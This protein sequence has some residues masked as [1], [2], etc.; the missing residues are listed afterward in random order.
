MRETA[1][2][3]SGRATARRYHYVPSSD[4]SAPLKFLV[5]LSLLIVLLAVLAGVAL[6]DWAGSPIREGART[7]IEVTIVPRSSVRSIA[8]QLADAGLPIQPLLL[9]ALARFEGRATK[10]QAGTYV[11]A[12]SSTPDAVLTK[13][14]SGDVLRIAL[15]IPEGWTFAQMRAAIARHPDIKQTAAAMT[16]A[17]LMAAIGAA[18]SQPE[19]E[20]FPDTYIFTRGTT[21]LD[22]FRR[23]YRA[24]QKR[25]ADAW[26]ARAADL[27]FATPYEALT[28]ASVVE[29][30]TG[31]AEDR[32][33]IAA[34]FVNRL[35]RGM[36]LQ[37]DPTV[38][39]GM[40]ARFDGN[41]RKA[42]LTSDTPYNTYLRPGLPPTPIALVGAAALAAVVNPPG[43]DA[44]YFVSRGDGT[45]VFSNRLVDHNRAVD[46][47]QRGRFDGAP[48]HREKP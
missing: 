6:H 36:L 44:L 8:T 10:L 47:Y 1:S 3:A 2:A 34:V 27:P 12:S 17:E 14:E 41:L 7:G 46:R 21:D 43:S 5:R 30:E 22:L 26:T 28:L 25:L 11:I 23:A 9:V 4:R 24:L 35:R 15:V 18:T 48:D 45:S 40:G 38:I 39:Y 32:P 20:F 37:T 33:L 31:R 42:D 29:K 19:G 13:L 16:D